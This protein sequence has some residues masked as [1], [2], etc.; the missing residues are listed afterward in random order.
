MASFTTKSSGAKS[1]DVMWPNKR[2]FQVP[3][4]KKLCLHIEQA[5]ADRIEF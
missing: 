2:V 3:A 5:G 4:A 1:E